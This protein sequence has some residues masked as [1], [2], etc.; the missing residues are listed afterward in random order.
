MPAVRSRL[1]KFYLSTDAKLL[2]P[3]TGEGMLV[4]HAPADEPKPKT[5][6]SAGPVQPRSTLP[7]F[8]VLHSSLERGL[9]AEPTGSVHISGQ[10]VKIPI[11]VVEADASQVEERRA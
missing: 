11:H 1:L 5:S 9:D 7:A 6:S 2:G 3:P 8:L 4:A 10:T